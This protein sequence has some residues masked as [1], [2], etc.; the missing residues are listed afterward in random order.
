MYRRLAN[1]IGRGAAVLALVCVAG[2][3]AAAL[4]PQGAQTGAPDQAGIGALTVR[5]WE[6]DLDDLSEELAGR[7]VDL[8][9]MVR[10]Q[11]YYGAVSAL[12][13]RIPSMSSGETVAGL[14]ELAA[15]ANDENTLIW[16]FQPALGYHI[17]PVQGYW[18]DDGVFVTSA[19]EEYLYIVG[20][21]IAKVGGID[22]DDVF[23]RVAAFIGAENEHHK[24]TWFFIY[25]FC[26]ELLHAL[27]ITERTD[28]VSF[29]L[30]NLKGETYVVDVSAVPF[31][32]YAKKYFLTPVHN[33]FTPVVTNKRAKNFWFRFIPS[34]RT[35]YVQLNELRDQPGGEP[36]EGFISRVSAFA[37]TTAFD[38]FVL[39]L[40]RRGS[41][42]GYLAGRFA[43]FV[44][45]H[46][47][48]NRRGRLF[49]IIGR[50]TAGT[51]LELASMLEYRTKTIFVGEPTGEGP[52]GTGESGTFKLPHSK[53]EVYFT[54]S[55]TFTSI[56]EDNRRFI[57]PDINAGYT[58][59][60]YLDGRDP[61]MAA[62]FG[63]RA[64]RPAE[65]Q[66][67]PGPW[68]QIVGRY[69]FSRHQILE[70]KHTGDEPDGD[71]KMTV[72]DF[73]DG[74]SF[75]VSSALYPVSR[76]KYNTDIK[77]VELNVALEGDKP[78]DQ[79]FLS[80]KGTSKTIKRTE[81]GYLLPVEL[82]NLGRIEAGVTAMLADKA[83][84]EYYR[85]NTRIY[86][87]SKGYDLLEQGRLD[88]AIRIFR[89]NTEFNPDD[90]LVWIGLGDAFA[91]KD[92]DELARRFY[93]KSLELDPD[94]KT[95]AQRLSGME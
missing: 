42:S 15:I 29:T 90:A 44:S 21:R 92:N 53:I 17:L 25:G 18:F 27:G 91:A 61:A 62:I 82:I 74:G 67:H 69:L 26:P 24:K 73:I 84:R 12:R 6:E 50:S 13:N 52:N 80:W 55:F 33:K 76:I 63:Y 22:V 59:Q 51:M 87:E 85:R 93:G 68:R 56:P 11:D 47:A 81:E 78:A 38:R 1:I 72:S 43:D 19:D 65:S 23:E 34:L 54:K 89:A 57:T 40:R 35:V 58:Y 4:A 5:Q 10:R 71:L 28:A 39:D 8:F 3:V 14:L 83:S 60:D 66:A 95:A 88:D 45:E 46:E 36:F 86:L 79:L 75:K 77:G 37:D 94:N 31:A 9:K 41:G 7:H 16:P 2:P 30:V 20:S 32:A 70:I 49:T 64:A 48:I